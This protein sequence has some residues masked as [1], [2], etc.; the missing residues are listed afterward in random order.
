MHRTKP[1]KTLARARCRN[2]LMV[3][4][5][6]RCERPARMP[7]SRWMP[8]GSRWVAVYGHY[9]TLATSTRLGLVYSAERPH[10]RVVGSVGVGNSTHWGL[11]LHVMGSIRRRPRLLRVTGALYSWWALLVLARTRRGAARAQLV[12]TRTQL[13]A[14]RALHVRGRAQHGCHNTCCSG[15]R[16]A[17][18]SLLVL[19][20][21]FGHCTC[22]V[23]TT[24]ARL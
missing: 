9:S 6:H 19:F 22:A 2:Q 1:T 15:V 7:P 16:R 23:G 10:T 17:V 24:R 3:W 14:T 4:V 11:S 12:R 21:R 13:G 8:R 20:V 18:R 5:P